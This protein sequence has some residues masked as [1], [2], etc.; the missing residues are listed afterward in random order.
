ML[1]S[2]SVVSY[3]LLSHGSRMPGFPVLHHLPELAQTHV[4][5]VG[6]AIQLSHPLSSPS[7]PAFCLSQHRVFSSE[8]A[9]CIWWLKYWNFSISPSS[10][11]SAFISFR[12]DWF[13][14]LAVQGTLK[15]SFLT[16]QFESIK[17]YDINSLILCQ[18]KQSSLRGRALKFT[19]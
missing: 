1:L 8:S 7:P 17:F 16:Q 11:Y 18:L 3:S 15:E 19:T 12:I 10:E 14:L 5:W 6:D 9:L 2:C 4:H 13:D